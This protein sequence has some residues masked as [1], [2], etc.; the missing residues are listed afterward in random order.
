VDKPPC[1]AQT[2]GVSAPSVKTTAA[3]PATEADRASA[4]G[5]QAFL[6]G[7]D[8]YRTLFDGLPGLAYLGR[9]DQFHTLDLISQAGR[10][11]LGLEPQT[12]AFQLASRIHPEDRDRVVEYLQ[13]AGAQPGPYAVEYRI[14]RGPETWHT[15][16]DQGRCFH[17]QGHP[18]LQ[19][20]LLDLTPHLRQARAQL[21]AE[22]QLLQRQKF[23]ALNKLAGGAAHEFNNIVAGLLGS[24]ELLAM[25]IPDN[26][27]LY[28]SL[29]HIFQASNNAR[30]FVQKIRQFAQ[31]QPPSRQPVRLQTLID[32]CLQILCSLIPADKV[33]VQVQLDPDCP[34]ALVDA[35]QIQQAL[36]DLCLQSWQ[37]LADRRG[38]IHIQLEV[39]TPGRDGFSQVPAL[40]AGRYARI[41]VRDNSPGMEKS[42]LDRIFDPF[43]TRRSTGKKTGLEMFQVRETIQAHQGEIIVESEPGKGV[44]C[45]I[46]LP[47]AEEN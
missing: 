25:D 32:E 2:G 21:D 22:H 11:F 12:L 40:R 5:I 39:G 15:V 41:T 45:F 30:E 31:R 26:S 3:P 4:A 38:R 16:W 13:A 20:Q 47:L 34:K 9:A 36:I 1:L 17:W 6:A 7:A 43:H 14:C 8:P 44:A 10:D 27:P 42:A 37:L 33:D 18:L 29:R 46:Y 24:A 35:P 23:E 28:E 19:G